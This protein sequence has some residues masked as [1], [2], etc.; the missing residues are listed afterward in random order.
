MEEEKDIIYELSEGGERSVE[1]GERFESGEQSVE[2]GGLLQFAEDVEGSDCSDKSD[3]SENSDNS[4]HSENA[5]DADNADTRLRRMIEE[6]GAETLLEIIK[7]N[8]N[9]AIRQIISEVEASQNRV[10]QSG[11]SAARACN[12]IF[13]LAALA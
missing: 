2:S 9:A 6:V 11:V 4:D 10:L 8:R 13:D 3:E 12:S 1:S 7:D 5:D